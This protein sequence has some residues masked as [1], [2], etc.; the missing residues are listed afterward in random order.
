MWGKVMIP[1]Y[2]YDYTG[3]VDHMDLAVRDRFY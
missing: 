1:M 2:N 3:Y